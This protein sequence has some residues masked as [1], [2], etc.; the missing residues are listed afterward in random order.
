M[1]VKTFLIR[2]LVQREMPAV[3]VR[4]RVLRGFR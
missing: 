1:V 4:E 3:W 2:F